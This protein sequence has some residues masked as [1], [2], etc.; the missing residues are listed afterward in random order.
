[1]PRER[2]VAAGQELGRQR[3]ERL[4]R[5]PPRDGPLAPQARESGLSLSRRPLLP[6]RNCR[7]VEIELGRRFA[8]IRGRH[9]ATLSAK[10][11]GMPPKQQQ[12]YKRT[13]FVVRWVL[14]IVLTLV[15]LILITA[16]P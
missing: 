9:R 15:G 4:N 1:M 16:D 10:S 7:E 11:Y 13:L 6:E 5:A 14:L 3:N 8:D 2:P 12:E